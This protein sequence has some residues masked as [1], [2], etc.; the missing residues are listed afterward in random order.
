MWNEQELGIM[1]SIIAYTEGKWS[2]EEVA[3]MFKHMKDH[4]V[5]PTFATVQPIVPVAITH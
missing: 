5:S 4:F 2:P 3:K 1:M